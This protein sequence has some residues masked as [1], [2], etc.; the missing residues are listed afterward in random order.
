M[1]PIVW[2]R[3]KAQSYLF[4]KKEIRQ[5]K[6]IDFEISGI[7]SK[8]AYEGIFGK[9]IKNKDY[10]AVR[11][12]IALLPIPDTL[13]EY[14]RGK[15][16]QALRTNISRAA[17]NGYCCGYF[18]GID[19][20]DDIM[21]INLSSES[22]GG[23]KMEENYVSRDM[24]KEFLSDLPIMFG[25]FT[26][27]GKLVGYIHVLITGTMMATNKIIGHEAHL[28]NGVMYFMITELVKENIEKKANVTHVMY[29]NYLSGRSHAGYTYFKRKCGFEG[30]NVRF[31]LHYGNVKDKEF[32]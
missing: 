6:W 4:M 30:Y 27:E 14:V 28:D 21:E 20:L 18:T 16:K 7:S 31:H 10:V 2:F 12:N 3:G 8:A 23:R 25:I 5:M 29:A 11:K 15:T 17:K 26:S 19:Y 9:P 24:V 1:N 32:E 22:R 13:D